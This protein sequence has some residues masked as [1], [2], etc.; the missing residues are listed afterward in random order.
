MKNMATTKIPIL[1][2]YEVS[3]EIVKS[4]KNIEGKTGVRVNFITLPDGYY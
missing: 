3:N 2:Y 4:R 1:M